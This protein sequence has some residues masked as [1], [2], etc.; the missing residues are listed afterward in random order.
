MSEHLMFDHDCGLPEYF[1]LRVDRVPSVHT[2]KALWHLLSA[3][4]VRDMVVLVR[5]M[6][7]D[8]DDGPMRLVFSTHPDTIQTAEMAQGEG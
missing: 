2:L 7:P 3:M 8:H 6:G 1:D 5:P 4:Q